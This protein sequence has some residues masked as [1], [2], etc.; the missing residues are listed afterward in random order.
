MWHNKKKKLAR[1]FPE[2]KNLL[3][4]AFRRKQKFQVL[5]ETVQLSVVI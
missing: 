4:L 5:Q 2:N 3:I 1:I